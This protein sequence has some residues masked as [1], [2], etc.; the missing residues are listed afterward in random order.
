VIV[1]F[2]KPGF[3]TVITC[4]GGQLDFID[5]AQFLAPDRTGVQRVF[6]F[7]LAGIRSGGAPTDG[8]GRDACGYG[9]CAQPPSS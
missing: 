7:R 6:D 1:Q 3:D 8:S 4:F 5:K 9:S 2:A